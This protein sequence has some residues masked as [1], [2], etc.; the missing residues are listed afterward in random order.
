MAGYIYVVRRTCLSI[1]SSKGCAKMKITVLDGFAQADG[2]S[3]V[4]QVLQENA[5]VNGHRFDTIPLREL[6]IAPC[7]GC[8]GC[9]I[10]T[11]GSCVIRDAAPDVT[12]AFIGSDLVVLLTPITFGGYSSVLKRALDRSIGIIRPEFQKVSGEI[13]H[14]K[15]YSN[16]PRILGLGLIDRP[17]EEQEETFKYLVSRNAINLFAKEARTVVVHANDSSSLK[18]EKLASSMRGWR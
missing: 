16:Y 10:K 17:D 11:P 6:K 9:W 3:T 7:I 5:E 12:K 2:S 4:L 15:R 8:F 14:R 18:A 13:H 1:I